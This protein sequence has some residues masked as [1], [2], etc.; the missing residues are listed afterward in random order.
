M[1]AKDARAKRLQNEAHAKK[2]GGMAL[3]SRSWRLVLAAKDRP[4]VDCGAYFPGR[5]D[6]MSLD[7]RD[8]DSKHPRLKGKRNGNIRNLPVAAVVAELEKCDA[9]CL[10]CHADRTHEQR[11][12]GKIDT[13]T[14]S[15]QARR[16]YAHDHQVEL[17][18]LRLA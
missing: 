14:R 4:C 10:L 2:H 12:A 6:K 11:A 5:P 9:V 15:A 3:R 13:S 7:H 8:P 1:P 16:Q 17:P 18:L